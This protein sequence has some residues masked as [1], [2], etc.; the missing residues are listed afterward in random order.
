VNVYNSITR[1]VA[2]V[3]TRIFA[4]K[5][6]TTNE[7]WLQTAIQYTGHLVACANALKQIPPWL[8]PL[9]YR[10]TPEYK[11]LRATN[12][13]AVRLVKPLIEARREAMD[14]PDFNGGNDMLQWMLTERVK[15]SFHDRDYRY[16]AQFQLQLAFAAIHTTSMAVTNMLYDAVAHPEL[17]EIIREEVQEELKNNNGSW[18]GQFLKKLQKTDSIMKESQ[19]HN[20]VGFSK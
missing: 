3:S 15:K 18:E 16:L 9:L 12:E 14:R 17:L 6:L 7:E 8:R 4:G 2:A 10:F 1:V 19:R 11:R 5:E 13:A 20:P